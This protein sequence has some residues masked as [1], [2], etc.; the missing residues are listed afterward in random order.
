MLLTRP[1]LIRY[2][3]AQLPHLPGT[4]KSS[5]NPDPC[6]LAQVSIDAAMFMAQVCSNALSVGLLLDNMCMLK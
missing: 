6:K 5:D 4:L 1:F 3:M 2:L